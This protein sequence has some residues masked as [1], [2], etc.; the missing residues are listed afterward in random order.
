MTSNDLHDLLNTAAAGSETVG[1]AEEAVAHRIR[2]RRRRTAR[3]AAVGAAVTT[4]AVVSAVVWAVRPGEPQVAAAP[5][6]V[7]FPHG[8]GAKLT[9][10]HP[11]ESPLRVTIA[12][13]TI[14]RAA[15]YG[16]VT[17]VLTN[18]S[19]ATV[20]GSTAN[21]VRVVVVKNGTVV[22]TMG[23]IAANAIQLTLAAGASETLA[24]P[25][26][27]DHC[28]TA[29]TPLLPGTYQLYTEYSVSLTPTADWS[30]LRSGPWTV[31]L[32]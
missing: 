17:G 31:E 30:V 11:A 16:R 23:P 9:G 12:E 20:N 6:P 28:G 15:G 21:A 1:I 18:D 2:R 22:A 25:V 8:C 5:A 7:P 4:V 29:P 10:Q 3:F 13:Q 14:Q 32:K 19:R 27:L 26:P 24:I